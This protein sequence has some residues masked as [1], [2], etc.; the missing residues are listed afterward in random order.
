[1]IEATGSH[2]SMPIFRNGRKQHASGGRPLFL[3]VS[4]FLWA[5]IIILFTFRIVPSSLDDVNY[6]NYFRGLS[7][8]QTQSGGLLYHLYQYIINEPLWLTYTKLLSVFFTPEDCVRVTI[9]IS[10]V[11]LAF[12]SFINGRPLTFLLLY[13][14]APNLLLVM[15]YTQ[16]RQGLAIAIFMLLFS[17]TK[18][19]KKGALVACLV[20]S[21]FLLL[22]LASF[23]YS[24][25]RN[26]WSIV[27][28]L[29][30][31]AVTFFILSRSESGLI[32]GGRRDFYLSWQDVLNVKFWI[33]IITI[34]VAFFVFARRLARAGISNRQLVAIIDLS[35]MN[36]IGALL[37]LIIAPVAGRF[38][39][40][41]YTLQ[42]TALS[43]KGVPRTQIYW[44]FFFGLI[45]FNIYELSAAFRGGMDFFLTFNSLLF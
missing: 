11:F 34:T 26:V 3:V 31:L 16:L 20:H 1:M 38:I 9:G 44:V 43:S 37:F 22:L 36:T 5:T 29:V 35:V 24:A 21:S 6:I 27:I 17:T 4:V 41:S 32:L 12:S 14:T 8:Y 42:A 23:L 19:V 15:D 18:S 2:E 13:A 40:N 45:L 7:I 39:V 30:G 25:K 28:G 10:L 33:I